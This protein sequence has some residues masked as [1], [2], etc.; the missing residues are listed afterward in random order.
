MSITDV[1]GSSAQ[2][3]NYKNIYNSLLAGESPCPEGY[4]VPNIREAAVMLLFASK[5]WWNASGSCKD[6]NVS[7][8]IYCG[9]STGTYAVGGNGKDQASAGNE[10][11]KNSWV[12]LGN[13][14]RITL[15]STS[16]NIRCVRD[17]PE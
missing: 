6:T 5:S 13:T 15:G 7:N 12:V 9:P 4:R 17:L 3:Q 2:G 1:Y 10:Q 8:W 16:N 14:G 11:K